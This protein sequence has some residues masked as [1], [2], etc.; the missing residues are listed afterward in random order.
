MATTNM[1]MQTFLA[2]PMAFAANQRDEVR[3][4]H[5]GPPPSAPSPE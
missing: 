4:L 2:E 3:D 5:D 1:Q